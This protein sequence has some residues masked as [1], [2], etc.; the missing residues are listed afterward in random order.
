MNNP[1]N[2]FLN[3]EVL[4]EELL[5]PISPEVIDINEKLE[6]ISIASEALENI[7]KIRKTISNNPN[8][9]KDS[10]KLAIIAIES[11]RN[12]L[13]IFNTEPIISME[14][15]GNDSIALEN[16]ISSFFKSIWEAIVRTF[17]AIWNA[18]RSLF[19]FT[20]ESEHQKKRL[21]KIIEEIKVEI[22]EQPKVP[23]DTITP[24]VVNKSPEK[25]HNQ[26]LSKFAYLGD[27]ITVDNIGNELSTLKQSIASCK[28]LLT[29][30]NDTTEILETFGNLDYWINTYLND[31]GHH[32]NAILDKYYGDVSDRFFGRDLIQHHKHDLSVKLKLTLQHVDLKS[33]VSLPGMTRNVKI[34]GFIADRLETDD[35]F[36]DYYKFLTTSPEITSKEPI[37]NFPAENRLFYTQEL[38]SVMDSVISLQQHHSQTTGRIIKIQDNLVR[39]LNSIVTQAITDKIEMEDMQNKIQFIIRLTKVIINN[40]IAIRD[41]NK[42]IITSKNDHCELAEFLNETKV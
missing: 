3:E 39:D 1:I 36:S 29:N 21:D 42:V 34:F 40:S 32:L 5:E 12:N 4:D 26:V 37:I 19:G 23:V 9:D 6:A 38:S 20:T 14:S 27:E 17:K 24:K 33:V 35:E 7:T 31:I 22:K 13:G 8:I 41:I 2:V 15:I 16:S 10:M 18:M 25:H 30:F 11:I 28:L